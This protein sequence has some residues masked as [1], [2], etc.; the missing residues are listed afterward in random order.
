MHKI[1]RGSI[2][3]HLP[4]SI[5]FLVASVGL[6]VPA[7]A[8]EDLASAATRERVQTIFE[9]SYEGMCRGLMS[10]GDET[11]PSPEI[12]QLTFSYDYEDTLRPY[13]VY[14][15]LCFQGAYNEGFVY[16]GVDEYL[17]V[18]HLQFARPSFDVERKGDDFEGP[19]K[20]ITI[21]G[22]E[23][24]DLI[25]NA[26]FDPETGTLYSY[27]KWR[28]LGDAF[29]VGMW[30]FEKGQFILNTYDVDASYDEERNPLRI[31]GEGQPTFFD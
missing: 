20:D 26:D 11:S 4:G 12:Y 15:Y 29:A 22:Y 9:T 3:L 8:Q 25:I 19:V 24:T 16:Y 23:T 6:A 1:L 30:V 17:E 21:T 2:A 18:K 13:A 14:E 5:V 31:Y 28:G 27:A 10:G 7:L